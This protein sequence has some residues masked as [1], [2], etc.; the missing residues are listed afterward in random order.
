MVSNPSKS[1]ASLSCYLLNNNVLVHTRDKG[2]TSFLQMDL[3]NAIHKANRKY[4]PIQSGSLPVHPT[5]IIHPDDLDFGA[6]FHH[7]LILQDFEFV[8]KDFV[9]RSFDTVSI[10]IATTFESTS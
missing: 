8:G 7:S 4:F 1:V 9:H 3:S 5:R 6:A 10:C 2:E